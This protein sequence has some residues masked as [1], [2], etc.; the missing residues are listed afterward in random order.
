MRQSLFRLFDILSD[1]YRQSLSPITSL[2]RSLAAAH[3]SHI[4]ARRALA[5]AIAEE[6]READ[7][8]RVLTIKT[9]DLE[10]RAV[11]AL[12][13]GRDDLATQAAEAIA[14]I[15]SDIRATEQASKHFAAERRRLSDL[16]RGRRM[17][18]I[19]SAL[20]GTIHG[21]ETDLDSF[22]EA[23]IALEAVRA[24]NQNA[25]AIRHEMSRPAEH[26]IERMSEAGFGRP[27][28]IRASDVLARLRKAAE[29]PVAALIESNLKS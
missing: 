25:R 8:R 28:H 3:Q 23:E 6:A 4:A 20:T 18:R 26:L 10:Q 2:N 27:T 1:L 14:A 24:N 17:A 21:S 7:R 11:E 9:Q 13:A 16:D 22:S 15:S 29:Q 19:D 12:R 5:I